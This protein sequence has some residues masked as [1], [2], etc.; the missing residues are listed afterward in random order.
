MIPV[1]EKIVL[2]FTHQRK[3][4]RLLVGICW[5][6]ALLLPLLYE[7]RQARLEVMTGRT[8]EELHRSVGLELCDSAALGLERFGDHYG[9]YPDIEGKYFFDSIKTFLKV[10]G[11][12]VYVDSMDVN[13]R[14]KVVRRPVTKHFYYERL[15]HTYLGGGRPELT[16]IYRRL[17]PTKY[18]LYWVGENLEDDGGQGDDVLCG[19]K[20]PR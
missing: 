11:I 5:F 17:S 13:G 16:I 18:L 3:S 7:L 2:W 1:P 9:H 8:F 10:D 6:L 14:M 19:C 4:V 20:K 12:Y 15:N